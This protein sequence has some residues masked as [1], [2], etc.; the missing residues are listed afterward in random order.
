M[1]SNVNKT[2]LQNGLTVLS[3]FVPGVRSVSA[4]AWIKAGS[5][6]ENDLNKGIAHFLEHMVF[7]GTAKRSAF[8]IAHA[9]E[10][11]GGH[12]NAYTTKESTV[13]YTQSLDNH[14]Q[15]S[16]DIL[17]D[18]I[19]NPLF[20]EKDLQNEQQ[21]VLEEIRAVKDTPEDYVF[22]LFQEMLFPEQP[23]GFPILGT[24]QSVSSFSRESVH[25]FWQAHYY[26]QNIVLSVSGNVDHAKLVRLAERYFVFQNTNRVDESLSQI[27]LSQ[28]DSEKRESIN[29]CHVCT[30]GEAVSYLSPMR[31]AVIA[32]NSYLGSGMSSRLFQVIR[33][34][35]GLAYS[36]YSYV[37]FYRDSGIFSFY[38]GTDA[39]KVKQALTL[40]YSELR[41]L[42]ESPLK[43]S[44]VTKII[45]QLKGNLLLGLES[46]QSRTSRNAKNEIYFE[47]DITIPE[48]TSQ[49]E[50]INSEFLLETSQKIFNMDSFNTI[51][52]MPNA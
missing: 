44:V 9:L 6:N 23:L 20:R 7:K 1:H 12:L 46:T 10:E 30:G 42:T 14:L 26:P 50:N 36:V 28:F 16:I 34:K 22:D 29:Q 48:I 8:K 13:F 33:E 47:R 35:H 5:R 3:E 27:H 39:A 21:V 11:V 17:A 41:R 2:I 40:L 18:L 43:K 37:D 19:C 4:G 32:L 49:I 15:K 38:L 45:S 31:T 51:K 25:K 24:P 52:L